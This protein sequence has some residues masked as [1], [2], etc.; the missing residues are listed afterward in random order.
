[1]IDIIDIIFKAVFSF[2]FFSLFLS[3]LINQIKELIITKREFSLYE[4]HL[5]ENELKEA[6]E[7][8]QKYKDQ[9]ELIERLNKELDNAHKKERAFKEASKENEHLNLEISPYKNNQHTSSSRAFNI[10]YNLYQNGIKDG[11]F[12]NALSDDITARI[13]D[14]SKINEITSIEDTIEIAPGTSKIK[15]NFKTSLSSCTCEDFLF[16]HHPKAA[17]KHMFTLA[18]QLGLITI[19]EK[20]IRSPRTK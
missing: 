5:L 3:M 18:M 15:Y 11:C 16:N 6:K 13:I 4:K 14:V 8:L 10:P 7:Q 2:V 19:A 9:S 1:M 20:P 17:C 12:T